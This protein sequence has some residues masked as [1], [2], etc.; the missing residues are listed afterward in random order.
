MKY[1][2]LDYVDLLTLHGINNRQ[3]LI[4]HSRRTA[5]SRRRAVAK[6]RLSIRLFTTHATTD[7]IHETIT[8]G[9]FTTS[10]GTGILSTT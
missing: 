3:L 9:D 2:Q 1:L 7:I 5:R 6:G 4:G 10:T 8:Q